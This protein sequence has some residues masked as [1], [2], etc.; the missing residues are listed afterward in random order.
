MRPAGSGVGSGCRVA[1]VL[2]DLDRQGV[3]ARHR[4]VER[5][6]DTELVQPEVQA[7]PEKEKI[8]TKVKVPSKRKSALVPS[9]GRSMGMEID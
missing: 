7:Q 8:K 2:D 5:E 6:V 1:L 9:E 4:V 3:D